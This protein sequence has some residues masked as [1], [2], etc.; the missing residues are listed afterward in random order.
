MRSPL[1][2]VAEN[3]PAPVPLWVNRLAEEC[4]N[5][6][7]RRVAGRLNRSPALI[8]RVLCNKYPGDLAAVEE[9]VNGAFM[10]AQ[11]ACPALGNIPTDTCQV[12][13]KRALKFSNANSLRVRMFRACDGCAFN[14]KEPRG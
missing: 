8:N 1:E 11:V 4:A 6:S 2:V 5:S 13:R 14:P 12:W 7:Q 9:A 10:N 3:W